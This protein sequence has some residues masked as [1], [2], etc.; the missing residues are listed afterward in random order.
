MIHTG[1]CLVRGKLTLISA[2]V[3]VWNYD[4][5][6]V[7]EVLTRENAEPTEEEI[8]GD[9][10]LRSKRDIIIPKKAYV[11]G[12]AKLEKF[13]FVQT[14]G[15]GPTFKA[16]SV[17]VTTEENLRMRCTDKPKACPF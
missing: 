8:K 16:D 13:Y 11:S 4:K 12:I 14:T 6:H 1:G 7:T 15:F 5:Q 17:R 9:P 2:I 10:D 3:S